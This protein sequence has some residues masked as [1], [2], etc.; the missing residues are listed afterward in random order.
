MSSCDIN[1]SEE[2][3]HKTVTNSD[4]LDAFLNQLASE[5]TSDTPNLVTISHPNG[6]TLSI[7]LGADW[8]VLDHINASG[9]PPYYSSLGIDNE[10]IF[11]CYYLGSHHTEKPMRYAIPID[12]A[13]EAVGYFFQTGERSRCGKSRRLWRDYQHRHSDR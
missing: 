3:P 4:E 5:A 13:R 8:T 1:W 10:G 6:A 12:E 7:V 9:N 2:H 11:T